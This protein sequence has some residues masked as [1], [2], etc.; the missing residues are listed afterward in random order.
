MIRTS[1]TTEEG[2]INHIGTSGLTITSTRE[3]NG[4]YTQI[5][6]SQ[7]TIDELREAMCVLLCWLEEVENEALVTSIF[8]RYAQE[9]G[10]KQYDQENGRVL[11]I[12]R[13]E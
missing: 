4:V 5:E 11:V 6:Y 2:T 1:L 10:K 8:A 9:T 3:G 13:G 7:T 12:M